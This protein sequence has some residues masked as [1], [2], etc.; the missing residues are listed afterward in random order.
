MTGQDV[1]DGSV[2]VLISAW[3]VVGPC[4]GG[5]HLWLSADG[6]AFQAASPD[7]ADRSSHLA[8]SD[9]DTGEV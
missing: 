6:T 9:P 4:A 7:A 1:P 2:V 8:A 5:G 3:L